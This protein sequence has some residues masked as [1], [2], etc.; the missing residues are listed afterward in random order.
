MRH[1]FL[2]AAALAA[3][4]APTVGLA[5]TKPVT[6]VCRIDKT[7]PGGISATLSLF[8]NGKGGAMAN[9]TV[10]ATSVQ[11]TTRGVDLK[12]GTDLS[13]GFGMGLENGAWK[14]AGSGG[15]SSKSVVYVAGSG[16]QVMSFDHVWRA[17]PVTGRRPIIVFY[18]PTNG[19]GPGMANDDM[20]ALLQ[21]AEK[22]GFIES[23]ATATDAP[24]QSV[25]ARI[26]TPGIWTAAETMRKLWPV[27][28]KARVEGRCQLL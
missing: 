2:A 10:K 17:G 1:L 5:Q 3:C 24:S 15:L 26:S 19:F 11:V 16:R 7:F 27:A 9:V 8:R 21:A 14:P 12:P 20:P 22:T 28:E 4:L 23:V 18:S 13:A 6:T 25:T